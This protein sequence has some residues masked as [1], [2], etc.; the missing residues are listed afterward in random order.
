MLQKYLAAVSTL[1]M[2]DYAN[3]WREEDFEAYD[4]TGSILYNKEDENIFWNSLKY[5]EREENS[6]QIIVLYLTNSDRKESE[7]DWS[8]VDW[9]W[10]QVMKELEG[11]YA[12]L[13]AYDCAWPGTRDKGPINGYYDFTAVCGLDQFSPFMQ[14]LKP[15]DIKYN[16]Y[17]GKLMPKESVRYTSNNLSAPLLKSWVTS[18]LPNF[19]QSLST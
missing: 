15:A 13:Y 17:T 16:P 8:Q 3:A 11:G 5:K 4:G 19:V 6:D 1:M 14:I 18:N 7:Q 12:Y 10:T 2:A 9:M